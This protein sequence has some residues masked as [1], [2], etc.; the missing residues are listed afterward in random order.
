MQSLQERFAPQGQC[1]GCGPAN[2]QG[3]RIR[4]IVADT[5][6]VIARWRPQPHHLAFEGV[7]SGGICSTLLDCH[8]NW[9]AAY[10]IMQERDVDAPPTT[11]TAEFE[12]K[13]LRPTPMDAELLLRA[14]AV[15][16]SARRAVI[17]V[18]LEADA[19]VTARFRGTFVAVKEDHPAFGRW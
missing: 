13:L 17:E 10:H 6:E 8:G 7:L 12:I 1:F 9:T 18:T 3:L 16:V 15:E 2:E 14:H 19:T 4:S 5:T 11:V